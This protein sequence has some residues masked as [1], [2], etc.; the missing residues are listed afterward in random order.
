MPHAPISIVVAEDNAI[1][2]HGLTELLGAMP[3]VA[4]LEVAG[5][6]DTAVVAAETPL[7]CRA[8]HAAGCSGV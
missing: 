1:F 7:K 8:T 6:R 3:E 4:V 2:A 5:D